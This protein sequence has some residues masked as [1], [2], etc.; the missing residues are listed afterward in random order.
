MTKTSRTLPGP[1][2]GSV[3]A[4]GA[5]GSAAASGALAVV[6][7]GRGGLLGAVAGV[8]EEVD[9]ALAVAEL[10]VLEAVVLVGQGEHGLGEEGEGE[11]RPRGRGG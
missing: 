1:S 8:H 9:V 5:R 4:A 7:C 2:S 3:A 6:C 11:L 10:G